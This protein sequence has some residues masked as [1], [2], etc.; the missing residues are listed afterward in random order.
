MP[1]IVIQ[2]DETQ[3]PAVPALPGTRA[4][5]RAPE[6]PAPDEADRGKSAP[7]EDYELDTSLPWTD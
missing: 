1:S 5:P 4:V 6:V 3:S 2:N 7:L